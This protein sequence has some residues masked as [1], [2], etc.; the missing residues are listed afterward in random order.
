MLSFAIFKLIVFISFFTSGWFG[1][2][3]F[4]LMITKINVKFWDPIFKNNNKYFDVYLFIVT[5]LA[6][7]E[8]CYLIQFANR[9]VYKVIFGN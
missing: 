6:F 2:L 9:S 4:T 8:A 5:L 7:L 1:T 3:S